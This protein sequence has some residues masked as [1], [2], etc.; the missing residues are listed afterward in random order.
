MLGLAPSSHATATPATL[1]TNDVQRIDT[2]VN[3]LLPLLPVTLVQ[4]L[5]T[6]S[7]L[8]VPL[9]VLGRSVVGWRNSGI[10]GA[11]AGVIGGINVPKP[12]ADCPIMQQQP[13]PKPAVIC[14]VLAAA[15]LTSA[16]A[17]VAT[18]QTTRTDQWTATNGVP[19]TTTYRTIDAGAW[20]LFDASDAIGQYSASQSETNQVCAV[21]SASLSS[22]STNLPNVIAAVVA[23]VV[24]GMK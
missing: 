23:G 19:V 8:L 4:S 10:R 17:H 18:H 13:K 22:T 7:L 6:L 16:C 14:A 3:T 12:L 9:M 5:A 15:L 20:T 24:A 21:G 2:A 11:L 1:D